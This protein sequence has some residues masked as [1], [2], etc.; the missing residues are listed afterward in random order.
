MDARSD[1]SVGVKLL[2]VVGVVCAL[3]CAM[4]G[5][6][7][8]AGRIWVVQA[9][10]N[11]SP[12]T[13]V[14]LTSV[15]C[16]SSTVCMAV[17]S[18]IAGEQYAPLAELWNG[19]AWTI[20]PVPT[21]AN[22]QSVLLDGVSC[23]SPSLCEAVGSS[24]NGH[25]IAEGWNGADWSIQHIAL[26]AGTSDYLKAVSCPTAKSCMAVGLYSTKESNQLPLVDAWNGNSK[27][28]TTGSASNPVGATEGSTLDAVSCFSPSDC[29]AVGSYSSDD[30][31]EALAESWDGSDWTVQSTPLP[32]A[33]QLSSFT[34]VSC[35]TATSC[36]AVGEYATDTAI[37]TLAEVSNGSA[38]SLQ[39]VPD[40]S[41]DPNAVSCVSLTS[42][43]SVGFLGGIV[44]EAWNGRVWKVQANPDSS[45][46]S[47][48]RGVSCSSGPNCT[49][50]GFYS[51]GT[52]GSETSFTLAERSS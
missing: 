18:Y 21:P 7:F 14:A 52:L 37:E 20:Q 49:A 44:A 42:C 36:T 47:V 2:L 23:A 5:T 9:T 17:G 50:V 33:A 10:P 3:V 6:S 45:E 51:T 48:L 4:P 39:P 41:F 46:D 25:P 40:I 30:A 29:T 19:G 35:A 15:S 28:W 13:R 1:A 31:N 12:G 11:P 22:E 16:P 8:A 34:G 27:K 24:V 32:T 38:W 26:A 43:V